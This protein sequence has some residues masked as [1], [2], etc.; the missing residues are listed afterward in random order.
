MISHPHPIIISNLYSRH[1]PYSPSLRIC[2]QMESPLILILY[3]LKKDTTTLRFSGLR[4]TIL[5]SSLPQ[6]N[7]RSPILSLGSILVVISC[8]FFLCSV[9][10]RFKNH[11]V[12]DISV[13][14][15]HHLL[16]VTSILYLSL[17]AIPTTLQNLSPSLT[18][19][20]KDTTTQISLQRPDSTCYIIK[21]PV[22]LGSESCKSRNLVCRP[23][24]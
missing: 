3:Q 9:M 16:N 1:K 2:P 10:L 22:F 5:L 13:L 19:R 6:G 15:T 21:D 7:G 17:L 11:C 12:I 24:L 14:P 4:A 18:T 20:S 8:M 23:P